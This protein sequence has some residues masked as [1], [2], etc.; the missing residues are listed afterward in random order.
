MSDNI[1]RIRLLSPQTVAS[2][3]APPEEARERPLAQCGLYGLIRFC[4]QG[5]NLHE[6]DPEVLLLQSVYRKVMDHLSNDQ[7][8][9]LGGLLLG[10]EILRSGKKSLTIIQEA[11]PARHIDSGATH[12]TFLEETWAEFDREVDALNATGRRLLRVGWYHSHPGMEI[13]LSVW[14]LDVCREFNRPT[15]VALVADPVKNKGG[16]FVRGSLNYR[17]HAP[18][19]FWE[20]QDLSDD[21]VVQWRGLV[22]SQEQPTEEDLSL[23]LGV[24]QEAPAPDQFMPRVHESNGISLGDQTVRLAEQPSGPA[25]A[26]PVVEP[27]RQGSTRLLKGTAV[28][29]LLLSLAAINLS[30]QAGRGGQDDEL[31]GQVEEQLAQIGRQLTAVE[32]RL[33]ALEAVRVTDSTTIEVLAATEPE[34]AAPPNALPPVN[35]S[36]RTDQKGSDG[37]RATRIPPTQPAASKRPV[38]MS[39]ENPSAAPQGSEPPKTELKQGN[40]P[41]VERSPPDRESLPTFPSQP[42]ASTLHDPSLAKDP[43][44]VSPEGSD[45]PGTEPEQEDTPSVESPP[46]EGGSLSAPIPPPPSLELP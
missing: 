9:E 35:R 25:Q 16:I 45:L 30:L 41:A 42:A 17:T 14:D 18:Q 39:A 5:E 6:D 34:E 7:S 4:R 46:P 1:L 26:R 28:G 27:T 19:G 12:L 20:V 2:P 23:V 11:L 43:S 8:R 44:A 3:P 22:Q 13:F 33:Q 40:E 15:Q 32:E 38:P 31:E 37:S 10:R 36:E 21:S 24:L 29:A